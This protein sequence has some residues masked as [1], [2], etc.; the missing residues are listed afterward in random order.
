MVAGEISSCQFEKRYFHKSGRIVWALLYFSAVTDSTGR[1]LYFVSQIVDITARKEVESTLRESERRYRSVIE[2]L[3]EGVI[4]RDAQGRVIT[5]NE[6]AARILGESSSRIRE[7]SSFIADQRAIHE[8]GSPWSDDDHPAAVTLHTGRPCT[9]VVMGLPKPDGGRTWIS[10]NTH[11]IHEAGSE[12]PQAV[13]K[14]F[15]DITARVQAEESLLSHTR[16]LEEAHCAI[17]Q[18]SEELARQIAALKRP[19]ARK[20]R[21]WRT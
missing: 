19:A 20:A 1:A 2:S 17:A 16:R 12:N 21:S 13:V 4:V 3:H 11:P 14:S 8:D 6:S 18:Q 15:T 10:V 7:S 9:N 5:C